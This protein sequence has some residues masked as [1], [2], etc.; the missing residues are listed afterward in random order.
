[1]A[2]GRKTGGRDFKPGVVTNPRGGGAHNPSLKAVRR[3][4]Q[5]QIAELGTMILE[6]NIDSLKAVEKDPAASVLKVMIA[7]VSIKAINKGDHS[8]LAA[9]LDRIV[10]KP[11]QVVEMSGAEGGPIE[12]VTMTSEERL[13]RLKVLDEQLKL[14]QE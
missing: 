7:S 6:G 4:S 10:G 1:M 5:M 2:K 11:K 14:T 8:A 3:L 13:A 9:I 12:T